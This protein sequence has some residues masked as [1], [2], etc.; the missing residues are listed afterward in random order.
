MDKK[1]TNR[2]D[3]STIK[4]IIP[5]PLKDRITKQAEIEQRTVTTVLIRALEMYLSKEE[6]SA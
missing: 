5:T 1:D 6:V 2:G 4:A 3:S